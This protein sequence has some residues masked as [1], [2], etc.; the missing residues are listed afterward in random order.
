MLL[1]IGYMRFYLYTCIFKIQD[2]NPGVSNLKFTITIF[3]FLFFKLWK[4]DRVSLMK[5]WQSLFCYHCGIMLGINIKRYLKI[6]HIFS[7]AV[8]HLPR[9]IFDLA[10]ESINTAKRLKKHRQ[11]LQRRKHLNEK[12]MSK[13]EINIKDSLKKTCIWKLKVHI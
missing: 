8:W 2:S 9:E 1:L 5:V 11:W 10:I 4:Y 12:L 7:S 6:T 13:W 3:S